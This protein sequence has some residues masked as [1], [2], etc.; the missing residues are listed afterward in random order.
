MAA[1]IAKTCV[2]RQAQN[3]QPASHGFSRSPFA[4]P[5][6]PAQRLCS[7]CPFQ[8]SFEY[9]TQTCRSGASRS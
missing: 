1:Q 3:F 5:C 7:N 4:M 9:S 6:C 8:T 2:D